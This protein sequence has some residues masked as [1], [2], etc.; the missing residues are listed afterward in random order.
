ME[1]W[2]VVPGYE[3]YEVST[4]GKIRSLNYMGH[5][6]I[7]ELNPAIVNGRYKLT[8]RSNKK[9]KRFYLHQ[10]VAMTFLGHVPDYYNLIVDHINNNP[11]DNRCENLQVVSVRINV[12][13]D[14]VRNLPTG[15]SQK[16]NRFQA[17]VYLDKKINHLGYFSTPE[18]ASE[19]YKKA[20]KEIN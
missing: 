20:L 1:I 19:A 5:G 3:N 15:V 9:S 13:K 2:K 6:K 16:G 8:L 14:K 12:T 4:L 18:E 17:R 7:K 11:L 10:L